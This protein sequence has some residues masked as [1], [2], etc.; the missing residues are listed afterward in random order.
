MLIFPLASITMPPAL[1]KADKNTASQTQAIQQPLVSGASLRVRVPSAPPNHSTPET[2]AVLPQGAKVRTCDRGIKRRGQPPPL[3][4]Y[5][6]DS[7]DRPRKKVLLRC[8][9]GV[10]AAKEKLPIPTD[11][12]EPA[13]A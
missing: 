3:E 7:S 8:R 5:L 6:A 2:A 12:P 4:S 11:Q 13:V 10:V 9:A 1:A